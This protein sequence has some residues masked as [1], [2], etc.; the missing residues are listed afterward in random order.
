M[1]KNYKKFKEL[2]FREKCVRVTIIFFVFLFVMAQI[3]ASNDPSFEGNKLTKQQVNLISS[4]LI[5]DYN[6]S[7]TNSE[8]AISEEN[9]DTILGV[10][11]QV[12]AREILKDF[13]NNEISA[14]Q[15]YQGYWQISGKVHEINNTFGG[16]LVSLD[17]TTSFI[18]LNAKVANMNLA[19]SY[20]IGD[21]IKLI[22]NGVDEAVTL[23]YGNDC[24]DYNDWVV[25]KIKYFAHHPQK[26]VKAINDNETRERFQKILTAFSQLGTNSKCYQDLKSDECKNE[27]NLLAKNPIPN[28]DN[29]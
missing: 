13:K 25:S 2:T 15:K 7:R 24:D 28:N 12:T 27:L 22:C 9:W 14:M 23:V 17:N 3:D 1:F 18:G 19:S 10:H 8:S 16:A 11:G 6:S 20:I 4:S 29:L 26:F 21:N 5:E